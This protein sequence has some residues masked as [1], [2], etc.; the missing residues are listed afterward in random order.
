MGEDQAETKGVQRRNK[1]RAEKAK[2][3]GTWMREEKRHWERGRGR[4]KEGM[5]KRARAGGSERAREVVNA[6]A[7]RMR[8]EGG[9][10]PS[11]REKEGEAKG[12]LRA[13]RGRRRKEEGMERERARERAAYAPSRSRSRTHPVPSHRLVDPCEAREDEGD[14]ERDVGVGDAR[15]PVRRRH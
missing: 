11:G 8:Q 9:E 6:R 7:R 14:H 4:A 5:S 3:G 13:R 2:R 10:E 12:I 1:C 15:E